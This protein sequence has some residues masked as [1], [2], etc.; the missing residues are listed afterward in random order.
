[1]AKENGNILIG[2]FDNGSITGL[3]F[4]IFNNGS[5]YDGYMVDNKANDDQGEFHSNILSY[6][7]GFKD[8][9]FHGQGKEIS[10]QYYF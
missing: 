5:Y 9:L 3:A 10:D 4:Y 6:I 8:N 7:G 1:M 2:K